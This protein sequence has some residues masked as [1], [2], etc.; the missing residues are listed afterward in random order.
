MNSS[1]KVSVLMPVYNGEQYIEQSIQSILNQSFQDFE[2]LVL[3]DGSADNTVSVIE[4]I[5]DNRVRL[6]QNTENKG[7][8]YS[9]NR[10][11]DLAK[12]NYLAF[13]DS[14]DISLPNRL[15]AQVS[16]LDNNQQCGLCGTWT[17][18]ID[19]NDTTLLHWSFYQNHEDIIIEFLFG[20]HLVTSSV[21]L[22][23]NAIPIPLIFDPNYPV[24]ED[25]KL[26]VDISHNSNLHIIPQ[27]LT[28]YREHSAGISKLE[29]KL[30][31]ERIF[32]V[33]QLQ[34]FHLLGQC[35]DQDKHLHFSLINNT[36]ATYNV[37]TKELFH[38]IEKLILN[39]SN[40]KY[41]SPS[42]LK[43]RLVDYLYEYIRKNDLTLGS[44]Y[45]IL[46]NRML[47]STQ[48][49]Y[50]IKSFLRDKVNEYSK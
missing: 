50:L 23:K 8:V 38:W 10:L 43:V 2:L 31:N 25:Y 27:T 16:Y 46:K 7:I 24:A 26:W 15:E 5:K 22:N 28:L 29:N 48:K 13:L 37:K 1:P 4:S 35:T 42:Q 34:L 12:A 36:K 39:N 40:V 9:R 19:K 6:F 47:S 44:L 11:F 49:R 32:A 21:M 41:Y 17:D 14:D 30:I 45:L 33:V 20:N 18:V 3:D